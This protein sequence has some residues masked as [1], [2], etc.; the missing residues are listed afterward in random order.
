MERLHEIAPQTIDCLLPY[1]NAQSTTR[2]KKGD[3]AMVFHG[4][5]EVRQENI[6]EL[7]VQ[8]LDRGKAIKKSL[9]KT[10]L[11]H[12]LGLDNTVLEQ[13]QIAR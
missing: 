8:I 7:R 10:F 6:V 4:I 2:R 3:E 5:Q 1:I 12:R 9:I 13:E 11:D